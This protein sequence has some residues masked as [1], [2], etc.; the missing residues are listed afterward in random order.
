MPEIKY[1]FGIV[2]QLGFLDLQ[3]LQAITTVLSYPTEADDKTLGL[4][5]PYT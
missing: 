2:E 4:K 1:F 3:I 5:T